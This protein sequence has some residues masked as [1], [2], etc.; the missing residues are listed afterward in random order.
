MK[1]VETE[2]ADWV[3]LTAVTAFMKATV[4]PLDTVR[5]P[6]RSPP[7]TGPTTVI[8]PEPASRVRPWVDA[9]AGFTV[10][11]RVILPGVPVPVESCTLAANVTA[12]VK[13][14]SVFVVVMFAPRLFAPV[15][16]CV[17]APVLVM[18]PVAL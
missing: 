12:V 3:K 18:A 16:F 7:P 8:F 10:P 9:A 4:T 6:N 17:K 14:R 5:A 13:L 1:V 15:P 2:P 11:D